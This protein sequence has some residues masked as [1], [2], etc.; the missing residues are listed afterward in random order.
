MR[1]L[2]RG[3]AGHCVVPLPPE[4]SAGR[5]VS[6]AASAPGA[7]ALSDAGGKTPQTSLLSHAAEV[8]GHTH[9]EHNVTHTNCFHFV[10][11][12]YCV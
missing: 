1:H 8:V 11:M 7:A 12:C 5:V 4:A 2:S 10:I 3:L 6:A 9:S